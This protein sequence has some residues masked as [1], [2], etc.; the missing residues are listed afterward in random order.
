MIRRKTGQVWNRK[1]KVPASTTRLERSILIH[2][3]HGS[4][5]ATV[6][7]GDIEPDFKKVF[8]M[9]FMGTT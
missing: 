8:N 7:Y 2:L 1:E 5:I 4:G 3:L 9:V 6:Y